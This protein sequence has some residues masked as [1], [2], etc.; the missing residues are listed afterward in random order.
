MKKLLLF[1]LA[2]GFLAT[3]YSQSFNGRFSSSI[4]TFERQDTIGTAYTQA[5]TFQMLT[6]N[7][8]KD[9]IWLRSSF[10][11]EYDVANTLIDDP[12]FR[13]YNL[14]VDVQ[15][16]WNVV[17]LQLGRQPL[18]SSIAGGVFDGATLGLNYKG[19]KLLGYYGANVPPYQ[20]REV[21]DFSSDN[22]VAGGEFSVYALM[23]WRFTAKYINKNFPSQSYQAI[24]LDPELNPI[25]VLIENE[26]NQ[27]EYLSGEV[28]YYKKK[29]YNLNA[30][31]SY[32]LNYNTTSRVELS[33]RYEEIKNLG[34]SLYY[35]YQEPMVRYN[36]IFSVFNFANTWEIEAGADYLIDNKYTIIGKFANVTYLDETSQR[37]TLGLN[38]PYGNLTI[39]KNFGF[40]GELDAI[41]FYTA[42]AIL[43]GLITPSV[44]FSYS[45]Y[46][47]SPDDKY[48]EVTSLL[49]GFNYRPL[50]MLS[51][52]LQG[53]Y[54][55]NNIYQNDWRL[56]FKI[57]YWF[58][59]II[60]K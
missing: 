21:A 16:L 58:N 35:N 20:S 50:R 6:F 31:Y 45:F 36:S 46:K 4:Y 18:Y 2:S 39:R 13:T 17:S 28:S 29:L 59:F 10:N 26:S 56:F 19:Y 1:L 53:Q 55:Y 24:R 7:F 30:R 33:G 44:G 27:Y 54:L 34:L 49:G 43:E 22:F 23:D 11:L 14:Y 42:F 25:N 37:V 47:L 9:N 57:N 32:D 15:N 12:R 51:F 8:G 41:S 5:R 48:S 40:A 60:S 38:S 3:T 52:D